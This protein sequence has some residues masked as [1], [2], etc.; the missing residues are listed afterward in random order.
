MKE[1]SIYCR[2]KDLK[3]KIKTFHS[4]SVKKEQIEKKASKDTHTKKHL[5]CFKTRASQQS[6]FL[7]NNQKRNNRIK[8]KTHTK[9]CSYSSLL[10]L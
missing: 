6:P 1:E 2:D 3:T 7:N 5:F 10:L 8:T 9:E 4:K